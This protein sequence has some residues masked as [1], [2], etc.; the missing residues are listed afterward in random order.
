MKPYELC[1]TASLSQSPR[2]PVIARD[3]V[4]GG[5]VV[6]RLKNWKILSITGELLNNVTV[7]SHHHICTY[8]V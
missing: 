1:K 8:G 6:M 2:T 3:A 7:C 4:V 5:D